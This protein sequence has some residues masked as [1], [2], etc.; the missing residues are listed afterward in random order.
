MKATGAANRRARPAAAAAASARKAAAAAS[1]ATPSRAKPPTGAIKPV[2]TA[3]RPASAKRAAALPHAA[4]PAVGTKRPA[5]PPAPKAP[6]APSAAIRAFGPDEVRRARQ[7]LKLAFGGWSWLNDPVFEGLDHVPIQGPA[8]Y[9]GNH[10][11]LGVLDSPVMLLGLAEH[12]GVLVRGLGD[13][14]HFK[15]PGWRDWMKIVGTVEGSRENC[16]E[17]MRLGEQILVYPGGALEVFKRKGEQ[18][19]LLWKDRVGFA[20]MAIAARCPIVPFAAVGGDDLFDIVLDRDQILGTPLEKVFRRFGVREDQ[21]GIYRGIGPTPIPRPQRLY[22][23]FGPPIATARFGGHADDLH[24]CETLRDE[25]KASVESMIAELKAA[26]EA[27]PHRGLGVRLRRKLQR[28][29]V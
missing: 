25:V 15:V 7:A 4:K 26:R 2:R 19:R 28:Q 18:Y 16:A 6:P 8:L 11:L 21:M 14:S 1:S 3:K 29:P 17:L 24:S 23:K 12:K 20:R 5:P 9:V 13:R 22:F 10:T 27:D